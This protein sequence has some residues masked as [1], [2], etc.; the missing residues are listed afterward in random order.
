MVRTP[1]APVDPAKREKLILAGL[2]LSKFDS[3]ALANLGFDSFTEAFNVIGYA[4]GGRPASIKNYRDEFDPLFPNPRVGW[5]KRSLRDYCL[6]VYERYNGLDLESFTRLVKSL[7]AQGQERRWNETEEPEAP[8]GTSSGFAQ[9]LVT[10]LAAERYFQSVYSEI[11]EF[12][13]RM[14]EN[15]TQLGCGY[16][17]RLKT[18]VHPEDFLAIEVKG[19]MEI[20]GN[21]SMTAKEF[22]AARSLRERFFLFVVKNFREAPCHSVYRDPISCGLDFTRTERRVVQVSW[23][24]KV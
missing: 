6:Q 5:H 13:G 15:T 8:L 19:L 16:D 20:A 2:Y 9:R 12:N 10:G 21:I 17:F 11:R 4:L 22:S 14:L 23:S 18:D 24:A 1:K 7:F 3:R